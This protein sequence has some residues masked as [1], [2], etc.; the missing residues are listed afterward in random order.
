[1]AGAWTAAYGKLSSYMTEQAYGRR[2]AAE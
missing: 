1:M 2:H